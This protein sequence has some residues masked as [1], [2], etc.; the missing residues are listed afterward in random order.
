MPWT[1][2]NNK[3]RFPAQ[4]V[5]VQGN[6][7]QYVRTADSGNKITYHFCPACGSTVYYHLEKQAGLIAVPVGAFADPAFP[8]PRVSVYQ[9]RKHEW[10][11]MPL[12][13]E[14]ER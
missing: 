6:S 2:D 12:N 13:V 3:A 10:I 1:Q 7:T 8:A 4:A 5:V 11:S 14:H 9:E